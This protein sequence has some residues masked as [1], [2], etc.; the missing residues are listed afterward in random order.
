MTSPLLASN[1]APSAKRRHCSKLVLASASSALFYLRK[2]RLL[3][4]WWTLSYSFQLE[5]ELVSSWEQVGGVSEL[6]RPKQFSGMTSSCIAPPLF[7]LPLLTS[8]E[9]CPGRRVIFAH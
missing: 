3:P 5:L 8:S 7:L 1:R 2:D 4:R 6:Q 9:I